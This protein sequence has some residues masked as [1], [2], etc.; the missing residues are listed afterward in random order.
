MKILN[1]SYKGG[2]MKTKLILFLL[3]FIVVA[4]LTPLA[5][6]AEQLTKDDFADPHPEGINKTYYKPGESIAITYYIRPKTDD[7]ATRLDGDSISNPRVY[8]VYTSLVN[9]KIKAKIVYKNGP[10]VYPEPGEDYLAVKVGYWEDGLDT[11]RV[12]VSGKIPSI[13]TRV[14]EKT[15]LWINVTDADPDVLPPVKIKIVNIGKFDEDIRSIDSEVQKLN[16]EIERLEEAGAS[17]AVAK[18]KL[19]LAVNYFNDGKSQYNKG[20]YIE[21][22]SLLKKAEEFIKEAQKELVKAEATHLFYKA[23]D[24]LEDEI[25][26]LISELEIT[27]KQA[28]D[29]GITTTEYEFKL[30][31]IKE[32]KAEYSVQLDKLDRT[33]REYLDR[34]LYEDAKTI[35]LEVLEA[36]Q[37]IEDSTKTLIDELKAKMRE[38]GATPKPTEEPSLFENIDLKM[39]GIGI[40]AIALIAIAI[41]GIVKFIRR[42][43]WD[44]LK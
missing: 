21:A 27:I 44:E 14:E 31:K 9:P 41:V 26:P 15:I 2:I 33:A 43:K 32:I 11:I 36:S 35:S 37:K 16:K 22:D 24:K 4:S 7:K 19:N 28:K 38:E 5:M 20:N 13:T 29:S 30:N 1:H 39:V 42:R 40:G 8:G 25:L 10:I 23:K 6:A 12:E 3:I 34:G 17:V 18:E